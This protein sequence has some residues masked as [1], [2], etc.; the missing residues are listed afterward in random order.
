MPFFRFLDGLLYFLNEGNPPVFVMFKGGHR[1][2]NLDKNHRKQQDSMENNRKV[3]HFCL[4]VV[5]VIGL[6]RGGC[7]RGG[8]SLIFPNVP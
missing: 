2:A 5:K 7:P 4:G 8:V 6:L 1:P 3:C